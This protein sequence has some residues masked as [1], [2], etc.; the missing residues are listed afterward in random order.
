L[1]D[2]GSLVYGKFPSGVPYFENQALEELSVIRDEIRDAR[3][4]D[5]RNKNFQ[6]VD[7]RLDGYE[8]E[9]ITARNSDAYGQ[10]NT[11]DSRNENI[12]GKLDKRHDLN[13]EFEHPA[14][15]T[16]TGG[17]DFVKILDT[18]K[19]THGIN[20]TFSFNQNSTFSKDDITND[21]NDFNLIED[22]IR[23]TTSEDDVNEQCMYLSPWGVQT[24]IVANLKAEASASGS[25]DEDK[26]GVHTFRMQDAKGYNWVNVDIQKRVEAGGFLAGLSRDLGDL[27]GED[28]GE[29][30]ELVVTGPVG[31][32]LIDHES[33]GGN[34]L[35]PQM[36]D[37]VHVGNFGTTHCIEETH[38]EDSTLSFDKNYNLPTDL[39]YHVGLQNQTGEAWYRIMVFF[40]QMRP[41]N[42]LVS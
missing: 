38:P 31:A 39:E 29:W 40:R 36:N 26:L 32:V 13:Q 7:K 8:S 5:A 15:G 35:W 28:G 34:Y 10:F 27:L 9:I 4:S 21:T 12:E 30:L 6:D 25:D 14:Y 3:R 2:A 33:M 1:F 19:L 24:V 17:T 18:G 42:L 41:L 20:G 11:L 23:E 16:F 22:N 37:G